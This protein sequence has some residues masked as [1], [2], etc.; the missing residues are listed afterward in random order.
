[1]V[2]TAVFVLNY[3][4]KPMPNNATVDETIE[5]LATNYKKLMGSLRR[6]LDQEQ[7]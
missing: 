3:C 4:T 2:R 7:D 5:R 6:V 1:M